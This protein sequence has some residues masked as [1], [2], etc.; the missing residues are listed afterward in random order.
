[1]PTYQSRANTCRANTTY[2]GLYEPSAYISI[3]GVDVTSKVLKSGFEI[4]ISRTERTCR[5][6]LRD[7]EVAPGSEVIIRDGGAAGRIVYCGHALPARADFHR[8]TTGIAV[9]D[10]IV[11][12]GHWLLDRYD[13]VLAQYYSD[14]VNGIVSDLLATYTN[15]DWSIGIVDGSLGP[16][17]IQFTY[18]SVVTALQRLAAAVGGVVVVDCVARE[19]SIVTSYTDGHTITLDNSATDYW[20]LGVTFDRAQS[21]NRTIV[22][23]RGS[24]L[25]AAFDADDATMQLE[26]TGSFS[27]SGGTARLNFS[28]FTYTGKTASALTG[29]SGASND[30]DEGDDVNVI[31]TA[32]NAS[33]QSAL[34]TTLGGGLSG[35]VTHYI[36]DRRI[37]QDTAALRAAED[38][39]NWGQQI[40]ELR[41]MT[42][43]RFVHPLKTVTVSLTKPRAVSDTFT[44]DTVTITA[45]GKFE[46]AKPLRFDYRVEASPA[47]IRLED[48]IEQIPQGATS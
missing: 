10:T 13:L 40:P 26:S 35:Q 9:Y 5:M 39:A 7:T 25:S 8:G 14:P 31:E 16:L 4:K 6:T 19:V 30:G 1:M 11:A 33:D 29:V 24:T 22:E 48:L 17:S 3:G 23:G 46:D 43:S 2:L 21:R 45:R 44:I 28:T 15:G 34:A 27:A 32:T 18:V 47:K 37:S 41:Y 38:V 36:Q 20:G 12:D 42:R